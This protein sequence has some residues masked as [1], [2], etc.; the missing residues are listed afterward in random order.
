MQNTDRPAGCNNQALTCGA[1]IA[2]SLPLFTSPPTPGSTLPHVTK[3]L[4]LR[5]VEGRHCLRTAGRDCLSDSDHDDFAR[6]RIPGGNLANVWEIS[7]ER[8][9]TI[10]AERGRT[11]TFARGEDEESIRDLKELSAPGNSFVECDAKRMTEPSRP[12]LPKTRGER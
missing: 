6:S 3:P 2:R 4:D 9:R 7:Y 11:A 10:D 1:T 8:G 12:S 5:A